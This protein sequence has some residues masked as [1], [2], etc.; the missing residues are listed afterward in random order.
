MSVDD[1]LR[2]TLR[3]EAGRYDPVD[4][5]WGPIRGRVAAARRRRVQGG[6]LGGVAVAA[7]ALA[8]GLSLT[9]G[10]GTDVDVTEGLVLADDPPTTSPATTATTATT[11]PP[12]T[13]APAPTGPFPGI[14]PFASE[15]SLAG[16]A[17]DDPR[18]S[19]P[20]AT[21]EAFA[22]EYV[23]MLDPAVGEA[24]PAP[25]GS[26]PVTGAGTAEGAV[27]V[28]LRPRG[29][30]G[31]PL[32]A[33]GASTVV[34]LVPYE[35]PEGT[36]VWTVTG[37][38]SPN[39]VV[40]APAAGAAVS[41]PAQV[42]GR[43][44]G[45]EGT[46]I[47]QVRED[48]MVEGQRLGL[49][50]GIAGSM[51][52]LGPLALDVPFATPAG[53]AGALLVAT[54]T[55]L[56][57][58]GVFEAT[59]VRIAFATDGAGPGPAGG[60]TVPLPAGQPA[61]DEMDVTVWFVCEAAAGADPEAEGTFA[62]VVRRQPRT[63]AVLG[64][65]VSAFL[66]GTTDAEEQAH[67]VHGLTA[68]PVRAAVTMEGARAIVDFSDDLRAS[69]TGGG[70]STGSLLLQGALD[71]TVFQFPTVDEVEYRLGGSCDAFWSWQQVGGCR[72]VTRD[73][74]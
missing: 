24:Q 49:E 16:S 69:A 5:G 42:R 39:V 55:G 35:S 32:P 50:V 66:G 45:Y 25:A 1:D 43:A 51:G 71:R 28:E 26:A 72:V 70:T 19:D 58:V 34:T 52:E 44:T 41:S 53:A 8:V 3:S 11:A 73:D 48:G 61:A 54:D 36:T 64:A 13:V 10:D 15:A 30:D 60:C 65:A 59:V 67:G 68:G 74:L 18:F 23:G 31:E 33:G 38:A 46:V 40:E 9:A 7:V 22:R 20:A 63:P 12:T 14:W 17:A 56:D 37:A 6:V 57:G 62:P 2:R 27:H 21:A 47:A 4:D 29:E